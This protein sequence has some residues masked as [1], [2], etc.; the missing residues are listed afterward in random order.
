MLFFLSVPQLGARPATGSSRGTLA[1]QYHER[2]AMAVR[3]Q[4]CPPRSPRPL[5]VRSIETGESSTF[6]FTQ[7]DLP[8]CGIDVWYFCFRLNFPSKALRRRRGRPHTQAWRTKTIASRRSGSPPALCQA[9]RPA[10]RLQ[11]LSAG[12]GRS[13]RLAAPAALA[14][15]CLRSMPR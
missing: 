14:G 9:P 2:D 13:P 7:G 5:L 4:V 12:W 6:T 8:S 3:V 10:A 15:F 1:E 11:I